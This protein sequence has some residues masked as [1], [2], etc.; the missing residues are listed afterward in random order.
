MVELNGL[1]AS[2]LPEWMRDREGIWFELCTWAAGKKSGDLEAA[3]KLALAKY[4]NWYGEWP[5]MEAGFQPIRP[6]SLDVH[7]RIKHD[8]IKWAKGKQA[9]AKRVTG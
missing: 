5:P 4:R 6:P 2:K 7:R 9:E 3:R 8:T 1:K